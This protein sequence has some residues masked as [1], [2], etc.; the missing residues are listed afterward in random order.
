MNMAEQ[1][2]LG[3]HVA[4]DVESLRAMLVALLKKM[5]VINTIASS[6]CI[7][8]LTALSL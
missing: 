6:K 8:T 3:D 1:H 2:V 4:T 5:K 7:T